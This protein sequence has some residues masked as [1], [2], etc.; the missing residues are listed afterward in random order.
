MCFG[1]TKVR[2][3][4]NKTWEFS[5]FGGADLRKATY[6]IEEILVLS[7]HRGR[8]NIRIYKEG[9]LYLI[10]DQSSAGA[11]LSF[12]KSYTKWTYMTAAGFVSVTKIKH[13]L[14]L[15]TIQKSS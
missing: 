8:I 6:E 7:G 12:M 3:F 2:K 11:A 9:V 15:E 5:I 4:P 13:D 1:R 14:Q 10:D